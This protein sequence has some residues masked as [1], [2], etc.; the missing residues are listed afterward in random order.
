[1]FNSNQQRLYFNYYLRQ[2]NFTSFIELFNSIIHLYFDQINL[3]L[4][5]KIYSNSSFKGLK[6]NL[7]QFDFHSKQRSD[8]LPVLSCLCLS[9]FVIKWNFVQFN[10]QLQQLIDFVIKKY[11]L[12]FM[13]LR[14]KFRNSKRN[15]HFDRLMMQNFLHT[16]FFSILVAI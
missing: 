16:S 4:S 8:Q 11:Q 12:K 9:N 1:M 15:T 6:F 3:Y 5:F 10:Y 14:T 7:F 2:I 13:A